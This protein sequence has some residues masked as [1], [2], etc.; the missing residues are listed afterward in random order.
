MRKFSK[1]FI[2]LH[3]SLTDRDATKFKAVDDY[4]KK[5]WD[6]RSSLG[7][8][9]GYH[10]F[11]EADGKV[12]QARADWEAGAHCKERGKNFD[13]IGICLA[14]NFDEETPSDEQ[15]ISLK[16]LVEN[17]VEKHKI[18]KQNLKFH[19]DFA[20]YKSCPG[21]NIEADFFGKLI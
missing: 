9:C 12:T 20:K 13:G 21:K 16:N 3:H 10:Y 2:V 17:L 1:K 5:Q 14:G 15:V 19:R 4:H 18:P 6:F 7:H 11:I 8:Y